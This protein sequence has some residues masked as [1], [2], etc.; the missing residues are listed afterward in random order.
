MVDEPVERPLGERMP[1]ALGPG[2]RRGADLRDL[3]GRVGQ[4]TA[5][6]GPP[7]PARNDQPIRTLP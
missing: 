3:L 7:E 5:R 1:E 6:A 2:E 4:S